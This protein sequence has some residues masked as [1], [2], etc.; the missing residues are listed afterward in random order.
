MSILHCVT[1]ESVIRHI[2]VNFCHGKPYYT[3]LRYTF[4]LPPCFSILNIHR[5]TPGKQRDLAAPFLPGAS[6]VKKAGELEVVGGQDHSWAEQLS[7]ED[8][9]CH[10]GELPL[11]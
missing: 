9:Y 2:H 7:Q 8:F 4:Y 1:A 3:L 6:L 10:T 11:C 5:H